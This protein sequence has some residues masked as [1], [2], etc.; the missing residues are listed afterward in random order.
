MSRIF[1]EAVFRMN[2]L[3]KKGGTCLARLAGE[4]A[5]ETCSLTGDYHPD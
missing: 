5:V 4:D 3:S 2:E 1:G